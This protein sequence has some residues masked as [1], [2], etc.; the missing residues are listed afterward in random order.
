MRTDA[1]EATLPVVFDGSLAHGVV[2]VP[3]NQ[4][5]VAPLGGGLAVE[6]VPA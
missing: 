3:F 2:Y 1:G 5:G 4:P 6:V